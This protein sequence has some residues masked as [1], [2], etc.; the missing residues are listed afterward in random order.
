M[1]LDGLWTVH[2]LLALSSFTLGNPVINDPLAA[3][4]VFISFKGMTWAFLITHVHILVWLSVILHSYQPLVPGLQLMLRCFQLISSIFQS[5]RAGFLNSSMCSFYD[6]WFDN[7]VI[8]VIVALISAAGF[9]RGRTYSTTRF[10]FYTAE[11]HWADHKQ[12]IQFSFAAPSSD[13]QAL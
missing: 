12:I 9:C 3:P 13:L 10:L 5:P 1:Q 6:W 2:T 8:G 7:C 4:R 11:L